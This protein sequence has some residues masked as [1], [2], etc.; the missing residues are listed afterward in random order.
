MSRSALTIEELVTR[1]FSQSMRKI[2][3][4]IQRHVALLA[5]TAL[6]ENLA[7]TRVRRPGRVRP[8]EISRWVADSNARRVPKFVI[9]ATG[10][11]T[12]KKIVGKFGTDAVFEKGKAL[13]KAIKA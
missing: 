9:Q 12:K 3:P 8:E 4:A 5:A 1:A 10:L 13:P 6:E 2:A 11:D 7:L